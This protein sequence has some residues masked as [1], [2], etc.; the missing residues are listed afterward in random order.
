MTGANNKKFCF[1]VINH[2]AIRYK[3][4]APFS[5]TALQNIASFNLRFQG[6]R[7]KGKIEL[8]GIC[9]TMG[10]GKVLSDKRVYKYKKDPSL[11]FPPVSQK[12][13]K[14]FGP[15]KPQQNLEPYTYRIV[16]FT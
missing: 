6:H 7:S 2:E 4:R 3:P 14:L 16:L 11:C 5:G 12:A 10:G 13:R 9:V 15:V 1:Y 8:G